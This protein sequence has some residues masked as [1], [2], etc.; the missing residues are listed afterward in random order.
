MHLFRKGSL[1]LALASIFCA[2]PAIAG[3]YGDDLSK[4]VVNSSTAEDK[5]G[6]V[7][8]MFFAIALNPNTE[9]YANVSPDQ[10]V[11]A[12]K[13]MAHLMERLL[14][15]SCLR[16]AKL[17]VQYEG[18]GALKEAFGLLGRVAT[19]EIFSN[20]KVNAGAERLVE[21]L[22]ADKVQKALGLG[23]GKE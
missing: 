11:L 16:E 17:A 8:W 23:R 6:L 5:Q 9:P 12:D 10:R 3:P 1:A 13:H 20:P 2:S 22:D 4:C 21:Y 7:Q 18:S 19:T 14:T 15:E